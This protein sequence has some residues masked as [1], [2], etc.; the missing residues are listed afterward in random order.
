MS[1]WVEV[2]RIKKPFLRT[3]NDSTTQINVQG[4]E[5]Q[6]F[7]GMSSFN[8][9]EVATIK[10]ELIKKNENLYEIDSTSSQYVHTVIDSSQFIKNGVVNIVNN[11]KGVNIDNIQLDTVKLIFTLIPSPVVES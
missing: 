3:V 8:F 10:N 1:D 7:I 9:D 4:D 5:T 6:L 2:K 11:L